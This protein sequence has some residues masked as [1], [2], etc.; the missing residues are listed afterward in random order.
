M[1]NENYFYD[2]EKSLVFRKA[3]KAEAIKRGEQV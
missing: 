2:W 1:G 3:M